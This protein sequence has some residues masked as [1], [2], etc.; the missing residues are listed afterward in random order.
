MRLL[1][2]AVLPAVPPVAGMQAAGARDTARP[3]PPLPP[4]RAT[5]WRRGLAAVASAHVS[6][7]SRLADG[8]LDALMHV[9][10]EETELQVRAE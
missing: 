1:A 7:C 8:V 3:R 5:S 9:F 10:D 6:R 4:P 2:L